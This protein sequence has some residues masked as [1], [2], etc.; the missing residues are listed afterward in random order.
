MSSGTTYRLRWPTRLPAGECMASLAPCRNLP[1]YGPS[2]FED[3]MFE[4][5]NV[6]PGI[7][8]G[9]LVPIDHPTEDRF[10]SIEGDTL[11][12]AGA[13]LNRF[14]RHDDR[15]D[16]SVGEPSRETVL[17][18]A[19]GRTCA[20]L[21]GHVVGAWNHEYLE[22]WMPM[23]WLGGRLMRGFVN[24][25]SPDRIGAGH[26]AHSGALKVD[27]LEIDHPNRAVVIPYDAF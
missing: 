15:D 4:S 23:V 8:I 1:L 3:P 12:F 21:D 7:T 6:A 9:G 5:G 14:H 16:N 18:D 25:W 19:L 26:R 11:V 20:A 27:L 24:G 13:L 22:H 17:L 2:D 10:W